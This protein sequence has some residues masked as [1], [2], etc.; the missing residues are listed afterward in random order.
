MDR[1][2]HIIPDIAVA[3]L[4]FAACGK[5]PSIEVGKDIPV[6][7]NAEI[8]D[9][10]ETKNPT[11]ETSF[12]AYNDND[13]RGSYGIFVCKNGTTNRANAHKTNSYNLQAKYDGTN[14][15]YYYVADL[16]SGQVSES[17]NNHVTLTKR[18]DTPKTADLYAY[19][20]YIRDAYAYGPT[21]IPYSITRI[22]WSNIYQ[23]DLMYAVENSATYSGTDGSNANFDPESEDPLQANFTFRHAFALMEFK[24]KLG[25]DAVSGAYGTGTNYALTNITVTL[26]DGAT[27]AHLYS[28]GSFNA[29]TGEFVD[30]NEVSS[31]SIPQYDKVISSATSDTI[32]DLMLVPTEVADNELIF[33]FTVNGKTLQPFSLLATHLRRY[34]DDTHS[35]PVPD[36]EGKLEGGYIYTFSFTLD[37]YLYLD[38]FSVGVWT[39]PVNPLGEQEI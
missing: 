2:L 13:L 17:G 28:S 24:F 15:T 23:Y 11:F 22:R 1:H 20:P 32:V 18:D 12:P 5:V 3:V 35:T 31:V 30:N 33:T 21:A 8:Q 36:T 38:D 10:S 6:Y 27:T 19:S 34:T 29:I 4:L 14:W 7:I 37:N 25:N 16:S 39:T 9:V 26:Q